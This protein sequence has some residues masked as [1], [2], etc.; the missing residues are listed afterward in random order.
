[1]LTCEK[2]AIFRGFIR[3][4]RINRIDTDY[5]RIERLGSQKA[6]G[7]ING[8]IFVLI[9]GSPLTLPLSPTIGG[10]ELKRGQAN[11]A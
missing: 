5:E 4:G 10:E 6:K 7:V 11:N 1:M 2:P 9:P 3:I 8:L